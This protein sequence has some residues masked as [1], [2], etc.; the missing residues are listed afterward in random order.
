MLPASIHVEYDVKTLQRQ[1]DDS[2]QADSNKQFH[3]AAI[4]A[5]AL[6]VYCCLWR[7]VQ[8]LK[9]SDQHTQVD[10]ITLMLRLQETGRSVDEGN[11][12][13]Y[14]YAAAQAIEAML[15]QDT[16]TRMQGITLNNL[17]QNQS[18]KYVKS[19][20]FDALL[21]AFPLAISTPTPPSVP[22]IGLISYATRPCDELSSLSSSEKGYLLRTQSYI[23]TAVEQPF[24]GYKLQSERMQSDVIADTEQ[25]KK[26]RLVQE[27]IGTLKA[28]GC[29]H[30]ILLSHSYGSRQI[31]RTA[32][33]NSS[34]TPREFLEEV[35]QTFPDLTVYTMLRDVFPATRLHNR[36][37]DQ[38]AFEI[39]QAGDHTN[40]LQAVETV[41]VRDT[42]PVYTFATL[43]VVGS[44]KR[45]QSGFC[46]Y[47]LVSDQRVSN[48]DWIERPRRHLVNADRQSDI[49]PC[50]ISVLRG[51]HFI[52]AERG[53]KGGQMI[54]V[55]DPF[56]WISPTTTEAAGEVQIMHS[57]RKGKVLL[58]YPALLSHVADVLHRRK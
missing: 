58:S 43:Y 25:L 46:V 54:P 52:E 33:H 48:L 18:A 13:S 57:R 53:V 34:L 28:Q 27:E 38:A 2:K 15:A 22:K 29:E 39:L 44:E 3:A 24:V 4:T 31:N 14:I 26:Q 17:T 10:F 56:N 23:A 9:A 55:L 7:I 42:I 32:D 47:F 19:G 6:I 36:S 40:F 20:T 30:I 1:K 21:S 16:S 51:L 12:D 41:R 11:G 35:S 50:L 5:F 45:P 8:R 37:R 49:H